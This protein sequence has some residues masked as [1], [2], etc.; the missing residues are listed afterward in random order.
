MMSQLSQ[1]SNSSSRSAY[2]PDGY[3]KE[4][5]VEVKSNLHSFRNL[6]AGLLQLAYYLAEMPHQR[7]LLVL[8]N[9]RITDAAL[10]KERLVA[11]K[12]LR[13]DILN[14]IAVVVERD[15][16]FHGV[17]SDLGAD[18]HEWLHKLVSLEARASKPRKPAENIFLILLHQWVLRQGPMTTDWIMQ[19]AGCSYPTVANVLRRLGNLVERSSDRR[20]KLSGFPADEWSRVIANIETI[21][22]TVRYAD[23][24]GQRRTPESLLRR[25]ANIGRSDLAVGGVIAARHYHPKLDVVGMPRLDLS[26]HCPNGRADLSFVERLD[27]ALERTDRREDSTA[28]A[29][30]VLNRRASLF[31]S[32]EAGLPWT[33]PIE[34]LL[35]LYDARLEPQAHEF[36]DYLVSSAR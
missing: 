25:A 36:L 35:G 9:S 6:R 13:P 1:P 31:Q 28:L 34:S 19:A 24:S 21:H 11:D 29:V 33:D 8:A 22:P 3:W 15:D 20:V 5:V 26:L 16:H 18:F 17:P 30:H 12:T 32:G 7:G 2:R 10:Q 27:P 23:R 4:T 14:R